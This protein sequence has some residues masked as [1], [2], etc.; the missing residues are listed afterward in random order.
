MSEGSSE[1]RIARLEALAG[2]EVG[3]NVGA[4]VE[5]SRGG[6]LDAARSL[7]T[8]P[9]PAVALLT[10]VFIPWA[11]PP[12][13]ETDGPLGAAELAAGLSAAGM[14]A[15]VVTDS[16]CAGGVRAALEAVGAAGVELDVV[17]DDEEIQT[18]AERFRSR[19]GITHLV[20]V[21]RLGP[22]RD[23]SIYDM[24]G[25]DV[26]AFSPPLHSLF[27]PA[28]SVRIGIGDGGNEIGM[29]SLPASLVAEA[30]SSGDLIHCVT[31]CD[32]LIVGGTSNWG[33]EALLAALAVLLPE[34]ADALLRPLD[35]DA[36]AAALRRM[37]AE[38]PCVD[39]VVQRQRDSVDG[40][41]LS[42]HAHMIRRLREVARGLD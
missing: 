22:S 25:R 12:A 42:V 32:H 10:G 27:E 29:G 2:R 14:G 35:P 17:A 41:P 16:L 37:V 21:E 18:L 5:A 11:E 20:S 24:S 38:G 28:G 23:G 3:R 8:A 31:R 26:S 9:S 36:S 1:D 30:I 15:R 4:L 19:L 40:V 39:G 6:L 33:A 7:A 13:A 34:R